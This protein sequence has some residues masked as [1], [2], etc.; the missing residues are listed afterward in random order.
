MNSSDFKIGLLKSY[1]YLS[2]YIDQADFCIYN[3]AL[4]THNF[5]KAQTDAYVQA[6]E[7]VKLINQ[8]NQLVDLSN[9][10]TNALNGLNEDERKLLVLRYVKGQVAGDVMVKLGLT[11]G[12]YYVRA[13]QAL[14]NF[15]KRL[16]YDG[17]DEEWFKESYS[18][19]PWFRRLI[20]FANDK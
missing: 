11:K 4:G 19:K 8:K 5:G 16:K 17:V 15:E 7:I 10:L 9:V 14:E 3:K 13:N 2:G 6:S 18:K 12:K 1:G 20:N